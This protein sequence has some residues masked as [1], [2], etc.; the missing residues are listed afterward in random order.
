MGK[1]DSRPSAFIVEMIVGQ[2]RTDEMALEID[3]FGIGSRQF[4]YL[5]VRTRTNKFIVLYC[6]GL[7]HTVL[8]IRGK[9]LAVDINR[10]GDLALP[11]R[12]GPQEYRYGKKRGTKNPQRVM[13]CPPL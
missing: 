9:H 11:M 1:V 7:D 8:A 2:A 5:C 12:R 3:N 4:A 10:V 6:K 13:H